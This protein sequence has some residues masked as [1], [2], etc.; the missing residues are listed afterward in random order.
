MLEYLLFEGCTIGNRLPFIET[1]SRK[2]FERLGIQVLEAP[3]SC[4]P[5]VTGIK[6]FDNTTWL[7]LGARNLSIAETG[8][9]DIITLCNGCVNTLRGVKYQLEHDSHKKE[10]VNS[11]LAK[12]GKTYKGTIE[13]KHFV[14]IFR[15]EVG[16]EKIKQAISNP[17]LDLKVACHPGC[18]YMRP[19]EWMQVDD[20]LRP[21][22]L[23]ELV[24]ASGATVVDYGLEVECCGS[25]LV[26]HSGYKDLGYQLIK[27]KLD[28]I[29]KSGANVIC[30][31][32]PSCFQ[33]FDTTQ[34][35]LSKQFDTE[36]NIPVLYL[37]ELYA[38][39][40][41]FKAEDLGLKYHRVRVNTLLNQIK[42]Y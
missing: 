41:G 10:N 13:T 4:C 11:V 12:V 33:Q 31:H 7:V 9:K 24:A 36:Y 22:N 32:C 37:T 2:V 8:E 18:H 3:F 30:V 23:K 35:N 5:D 1:A 25:A 16:L 6:S 17:L 40:M 39:A 20:P 21:T 28:A 14:D 34:K 26:T 38:L 19:K 27:K 15:E 42:R 29:K